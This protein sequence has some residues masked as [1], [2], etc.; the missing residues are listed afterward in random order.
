MRNLAGLTLSIGAA[1]L[2]AGCGG[3]QPPI[4]MSSAISQVPPGSRGARA[5]ER[6]L[7][8]F[9][10][11]DGVVPSGGLIIDKNGALYGTTENG[12][13][14]G[15]TGVGCGTVFKLSPVSSSKYALAVIYQFR[16]ERDGAVPSG[17][18]TADP[19]GALYGTTGSGGLSQ[20]GYPGTIFKL[21]PSGSGYGEQAI[22][23]FTARSDGRE[24]VGGV[25]EDRKRALYGVTMYNGGTSCQC[26]T[27]YKLTRSGRGYTFSVIYRFQGGTDGSYPNTPLVADSLGNLYGMTSEGGSCQFNVDGCGTVF[28]LH[29]SHGSYVHVVLHAFSA[30]ATDGLYPIGGLALD[31]S[32][33]LY[34]ATRY[35]GTCP[36][37]SVGCGV[38]F[39]LSPRGSTY[40][41]RVLYSFGSQG[42]DDG[43]FPNGSLTLAA[44]GVIYGTTIET[45]IRR[46]YKHGVS[47]GTVF[48][49]TPV[50]SS[51]QESVVFRFH[52]VTQGNIP[53]SGLLA[54][55]N[56]LFG[57]TGFGGSPDCSFA[58]HPG[59]GVV[60][61]LVA[62]SARPRSGEAASR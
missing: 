19:S 39:E 30:G 13:G 42:K 54:V 49:L 38:A 21:T 8:D 44:G 41:E 7:A 16:R 60:F 20:D 53:L 27:A 28:E 25:V 34:G 48:K 4:E 18:L 1:A 3:S 40:T 2:F 46:C 50:G 56:T 11:S 55:G 36:I 35:G 31:S 22:H 9:V 57:E 14:S 59:C 15:C 10:N 6:V 24:P 23:R 17:G 43:V 52:D 51:Y 62:V 12:D 26:G 58:G 5:Q 61:A 47:C 33:N 45:A 29:P 37:D 32:G